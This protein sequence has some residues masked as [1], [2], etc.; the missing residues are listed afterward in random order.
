MLIAERI[1]VVGQ[2]GKAVD[3][4]RS[5]PQFDDI[6]AE[7]HG[8]VIAGFVVGLRLEAD[9]ASDRSRPAVDEMKLVRLHR[10]FRLRPRGCHRIR[11]TFGT[12]L[13]HDKPKSCISTTSAAG[14]AQQSHDYHSLTWIGE[15]SG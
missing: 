5:A 3:H 15:S 10:R 8:G 4:P 1:D 14:A 9:E 2:R 6:G 12:V 7:E 13:K 11:S